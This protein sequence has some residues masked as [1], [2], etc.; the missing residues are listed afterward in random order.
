M[1]SG[2]NGAGAGAGEGSSGEGGGGAW[3]GGDEEGGRWDRSWRKHRSPPRRSVLGQ[4]KT[5]QLQLSAD[6]AR[7]RRREVT[8]AADDSCRPSQRQQQRHLA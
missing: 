8:E 4:I 3:V 5:R 1:R 2:E 6:R 7:G